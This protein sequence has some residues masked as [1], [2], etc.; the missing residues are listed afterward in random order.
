MKISPSVQDSTTP[1]SCYISLY[2]KQLLMQY[3]GSCTMRRLN[4]ETNSSLA[5]TLNFSVIT[6]ITFR[7]FN[8]TKTHA[9]TCHVYA[10]VWTNFT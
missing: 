9:K 5:L 1:R 10:N 2:N 4:N 7:V 3:T 6:A 8:S